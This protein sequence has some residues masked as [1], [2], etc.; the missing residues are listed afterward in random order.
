M[1]T[2]LGIAGA[3]VIFYL[4]LHYT[5]RN[6]SDRVFV[7]AAHAV[8]ILHVAIA[9]VLLPLVYAHLGHTWDTGAYHAAALDVYHGE[10]SSGSTAIQSFAIIMA[11]LYVIFAPDMAVASIFN[12][13]V[14]V[15]TAIPIAVLAKQLYPDLQRTTGLKLTVL[16]LPTAVFFMT[17]PMRDTVT[18]FIFFAALAVIAAGLRRQRA[19]ILALSAPL[20]LLLSIP[21]MEL[22]AVVLL[23]LVAA[24]GI[25]VLDSITGSTSTTSIIS[26][27][28]V[29]GAAGFA[30]FT[31]FFFSIEAAN[32]RMQHRA[33]DGAAYLEGMEIHS[34]ADFLL[35]APARAIYFQFMPFPLYVRNVRDVFV[36]SSL[37]VLIAFAIGGILCLWKKR[38]DWLVAVFLIV[39]Y[40]GGIV[41][42]GMINSNFGTT[43]RHRIPF[44][45][46]LAVFATPMIESVLSWVIDRIQLRP[47][48]Q[49]D[50]DSK[51]DKA[52]KTNRHRHA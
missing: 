49:S 2:I 51:Y 37:P 50:K 44:I 36:V 16:L 5:L 35:L 46:L 22:A 19:S 23:G 27:L 33:R 31:Q 7:T 11:I 28:G 1:N 48:D 13:F 20:I 18:V 12:G 34:W 25:Q 10:I 32:S 14:A 30:V 8:F 21:R 15:L 9:V 29:I 52:E 47:D 38:T 3:A 4:A 24:V 41:G 6:H 40:L 26:V 39:T 42:Y 17:I 43:V 45:Y